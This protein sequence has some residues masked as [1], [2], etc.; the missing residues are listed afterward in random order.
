MKMHEDY[1]IVESCSTYDLETKIDDYLNKGYQLIG[2]L[3]VYGS[4]QNSSN[5]PCVFYQAIAKPYCPPSSNF[6]PG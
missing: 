5:N 2:G 3:V 4:G 1:R 6:G